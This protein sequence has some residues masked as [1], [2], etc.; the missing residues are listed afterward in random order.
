M[1]YRYGSVASF[2]SGQA[3]HHSLARPITVTR[4]SRT[5]APHGTDMH[6]YASPCIA[7]TH[8]SQPS[9][10]TA[11]TALLKKCLRINS[12]ITPLTQKPSSQTQIISCYYYQ[13]PLAQPLHARSHRPFCRTV[14]PSYLA[15]PHNHRE[16][17][18]H[19]PFSPA[20]D[21]VGTL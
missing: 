18:P 20:P 10:L 7:I 14:P 11:T 13:D 9:R 21:S 15:T 4:H 8:P 1:R 5:V 16:Q 12:R 3:S 6:G 17:L 19:R 2:A